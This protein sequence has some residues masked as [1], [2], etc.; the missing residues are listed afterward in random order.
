MGNEDAWHVV[1]EELERREE[2][3]REDSDESRTLRVEEIMAKCSG[4]LEKHSKQKEVILNEAKV[5]EAR[6]KRTR[7]IEAQ[8]TKVQD[9]LS[10]EQSRI[11]RTA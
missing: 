4:V 9:C 10:I 1:R 11:S 6:D 2:G 3:R 7:A 8:V 5:Q